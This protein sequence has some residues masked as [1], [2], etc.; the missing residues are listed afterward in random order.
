MDRELTCNVCE[1]ATAATACETARVRSNV[2]KFRNEQFEVWRCPA[3]RSIH[4]RDA[5]DLA[6]YYASYPTFPREIER[7]L[8]HPYGNM[9]KRLVRSGLSKEHRILDYGCGSGALVR[10]L[11]SHGY[12]QTSGYDAYTA[13]FADRGVL[14]HAYDC[15]VSQDVIEHVDSPRALLGEFDRLTVPGAMIAIGTPDAAALDLSKPEDF[16]HALHAP[17]HRHILTRDA[18]QKQAE[19]RGWQVDRYYSTMY[20]N[21]LIP[22]ENPRAGLH[23][24]R[25]HDDCLDLLTEPVR[26]G[27]RLLSPETP[28]YML[29]GYFFDRHTDVMFVFRKDAAR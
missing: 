23:Y 14:E 19:A 11:R 29:F 16:V 17:Y 18:L 8:R 9:L 22:G 2:R 25:C 15:V 20:G 6:H 1:T 4:A 28:F 24:L 10:F 12:E 3:C 21:T 7:R 26:F 5:V 27:W 13:E